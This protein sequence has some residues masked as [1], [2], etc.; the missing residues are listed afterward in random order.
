M[1][2]INT[3]NSGVSML[4]LLM[5]NRSKSGS[6]KNSQASQQITSLR[7]TLNIS[8]RSSTNIN[9]AAS[10][11]VNIS[12]SQTGGGRVDIGCNMPKGAQM[13]PLPG[14]DAKFGHELNLSKADPEMSD[15]DY[16][17]AIIELAQKHAAENNFF[18]VNDNSLRGLQESYISVVSPD[19]TG[20]IGGASGGMIPANV[21]AQMAKAY[22]DSGNHIATYD[23]NNGWTNVATDDEKARMKSFTDLY[24]KAYREASNS[25]NAYGATTNTSNGSTDISA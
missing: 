10:L 18:G 21:N 6:S 7:D 14:Y 24:T 19:R 4:D 5:K 12:S 1:S 22:D 25:H 13:M 8:G 16:E 11:S 20:I 9:I 2:S 3:G 17:N 15:E 23:S